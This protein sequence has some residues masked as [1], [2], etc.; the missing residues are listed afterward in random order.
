MLPLVLIVII[1]IL[2]LNSINC[3]LRLCPDDYFFDSQHC[4][5]C[6]PNCICSAE[7][8]CDDCI[9]GYTLFRG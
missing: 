2:N 6:S 5:T 4:E 1:T 8:T 3:A 7:D 9:D